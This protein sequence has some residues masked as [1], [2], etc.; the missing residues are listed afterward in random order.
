NEKIPFFA[1]GWIIGDFKTVS[2]GDD[3]WTALPDPFDPEFEQR[4]IATVKQVKAEIMDSPWC[5]G[6]F[7][8]NEK[9]WG[10]MGTI[11]GQYGI[12]IHTLSRNAEESPTKAVFMTVL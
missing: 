5:V 6:I 10:R 9:S 3:F 8:D 1:N 12:P 2:S 4:A 7:I 11:E